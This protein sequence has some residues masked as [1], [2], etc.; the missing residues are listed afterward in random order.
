M[1]PT[2]DPKSSSLDLL[3]SVDRSGSDSAY[4]TKLSPWCIVRPLPDL[5]HL[6]VARFRRRS[7]AEAYLQT[8]RRLAPAAIHQIVFEPPT[9][10]T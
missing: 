1:I 9:I 7:E 3:D 4:R 8:L 2:S 6:V 10:G 5:Q